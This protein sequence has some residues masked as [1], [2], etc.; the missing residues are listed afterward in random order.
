MCSPLPPTVCVQYIALVLQNVAMGYVQTYTIHNSEVWRLHRHSHDV[1]I[2]ETVTRKIPGLKW[3]S[4]LLYPANPEFQLSG[5]SCFVELARDKL[6]FIAVQ[7]VSLSG[8]YLIK[9]AVV[10]SVSVC[11]QGGGL[12]CVWSGWRPGCNHQPGCLQWDWLS[13][14]S[15]WLHYRRLGQSWVRICWLTYTVGFG[16]YEVD[17]KAPSK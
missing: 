10:Y 15:N 17:F 9:P 7:T 1:L 3:N 8:S 14:Q 13:L 16:T 5:D 12:V 2:A 4:N 11:G 6:K